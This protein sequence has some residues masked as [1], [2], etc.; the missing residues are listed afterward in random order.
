MSMPSRLD[1]KL[2]LSILALAA[3]GLTVFVSSTPR[4]LS[5]QTAATA[6]QWEQ[7]CNLKGH[8]CTSKSNV[9]GV[10]TYKACGGGKCYLVTCK[11]ENVGDLCEKRELYGEKPTPR[12][13]QSVVGSLL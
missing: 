2:I 12:K 4:G 6:L 13:L 10:S 3:V 11:S 5:S 1:Q 9:D 7:L 8:S